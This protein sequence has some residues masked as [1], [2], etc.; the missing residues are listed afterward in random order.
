MGRKRCRAQA[1]VCEPAGGTE[2]GLRGAPWEGSQGLG[3]QP[4]KTHYSFSPQPTAL[5]HGQR[6][7]V[8]GAEGLQGWPGGGQAPLGPLSRD[9]G[10]LQACQADV[11]QRGM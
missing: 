9:H 5:Q 8:P 10:R 2:A 4:L 3:L 7:S 6:G 11:V 1:C